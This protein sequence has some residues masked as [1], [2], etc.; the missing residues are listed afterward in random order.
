MSSVKMECPDF[1]CRWRQIPHHEVTIQTSSYLFNIHQLHFAA[2]SPV[3][4]CINLETNKEEGDKA[5]Y[6]KI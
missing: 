3:Y 5:L 2:H 1:T 6:R 4:F